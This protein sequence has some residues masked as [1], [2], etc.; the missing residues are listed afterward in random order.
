MTSTRSTDMIIIFLLIHLSIASSAV[1]VMSQSYSV[2]HCEKDT[3]SIIPVGRRREVLYYT[4]NHKINKFVEHCHFDNEKEHNV[5]NN[6]MNE[7]VNN[8]YEKSNLDVAKLTRSWS[9]SQAQ[10]DV[11]MANM[12]K[13]VPNPF[14]VD[15][16]A[17]HWIYISNTYALDTY[18]H[19]K[20]IC[21]EPTSQYLAGLVVNRTCTVVKNV[22]SGKDNEEIEYVHH[23]SLG[24]IVGGD[25]GSGLDN[26][27]GNPELS[28][29]LTKEILHTVTLTTILTTFKAPSIIEYLSLDVR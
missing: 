4:W 20:G 13:S 24:G 9:Q 23:G 22:V 26:F 18:R 8:L 1:D 3:H 7:D 16:A 19:W 21:I 15:L 2:Q 6:I 17:N 11:M 29:D 5:N 27:H 25:K 28:S 10:Q 12:F 14:Y